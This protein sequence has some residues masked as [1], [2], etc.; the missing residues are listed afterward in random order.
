MS[1]MMA[2]RSAG[3]VG[4]QPVQLG[5]HLLLAAGSRGGD[6]RRVEAAEPH[7][8][9]QVADHRVAHL[10]R[11][12]QVVQRAQVLLA[13]L[14]RKRGEPGRVRE[15]PLQ[16]VEHHRHVRAGPA[17]GEEHPVQRAGERLVAGGAQVGDAVVG[18]R[19]AQP[20]AERL[21]QPLGVGVAGAQV[22]VEVLLR[23][24]RPLRA[25]ALRVALGLASS[26]SGPRRLRDSADRSAKI[27]R[28]AISP[29]STS[30]S[31]SG[32]LVAGADR[33]ASSGRASRSSTS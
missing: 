20:G 5:A 26:T 21:G 3:S 32:R 19:G 9:G 7:P 30:G 10:G 13:D 24:A 23:V 17:V 2:A 31:S 11:G 16:Q 8:P 33:A 27:R 18:E 25:V 12:H 1:S 6:Q 28:I 15:P 14:G 22:R 29:A 4:G